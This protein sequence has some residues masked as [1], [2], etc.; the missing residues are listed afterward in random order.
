MAFVDP[1]QFHPGHLLVIPNAHVH[2]IRLL[3]AVDAGPLMVCGAV[4]GCGVSGG[5]L[6][7]LALRWPWCQS[8]DSAF[9]L[10]CASTG[11]RR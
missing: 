6:V 11:G 1:R 5:R 8:G 2:D 3:P 7:D 10:S 4:G 9:A